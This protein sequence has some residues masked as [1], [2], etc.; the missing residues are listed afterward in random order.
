MQGVEEPRS[1]YHLFKAGQLRKLCASRGL[2]YENNTKDENVRRLQED[3]ARLA[4]QARGEPEPGPPRVE[5]VEA[6]SS[7]I[8]QQEVQMLREMLGSLE[9]EDENFGLRAACLKLRDRLAAR[10]YVEEPLELIRKYSANGWM[11]VANP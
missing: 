11:I 10:E 3:D 1:S 8:E 9:Q 6:L 4:R 2:P 7:R 5:P